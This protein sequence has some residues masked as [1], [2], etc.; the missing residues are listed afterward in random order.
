MKKNNYIFVKASIGVFSSLA[1]VLC[2]LSFTG[3]KKGELVS[4]AYDSDSLLPTTIDLNDTKEADIRGYYSS[5]NSLSDNERQG[6]NL[7]KNL[8]EILKNG[9]KYYSYDY[10]YGTGIKG[11][12]I[13]QMYE[14]VDRDWVKS[15]ASSTFYGT[16]DSINN[17]LV[18]YQYGTSNNDSKNNPYLHTLY[19]NRDVEN[20]TRAWGDHTQVGWGINREHIWAKSHG[21]GATASEDD[22]TSSGA[23]G[24]PMHLWSGNGYINGSDFHYHSNNFFG[25]V[26]LNQEYRDTLNDGSGYTYLSGNYEGYSLNK[27]SYYKVFEPQDSDKGDI[28]RAIF[29]MAARYNYFSGYDADGINENNPNLIITDNTYDTYRTGS[30]NCSESVAGQMGI[31]RD[32]LAWNRLD[33][34]DEWEIH[35]NNLLYNN[36]TNNRN[37]FIDYPEWAEYIWGK[38]TL[39]ND[40]RTI[41]SFNNSPTGVATPSSDNIS[42]FAAAIHP[43]DITFTSKPAE[44]TVGDNF[45]LECEITPSNATDKRVYY[46]ASDYNVVTISDTGYLKAVGPGEVT[47]TVATFDGDITD[48]FSIEV[49]APSHD[50]DYYLSNSSP[51]INGVPYK[52]YFH[53]TLGSAEKDYYFTGAMNGYYGASS[54]DISNAC[55]VYFEE[56]GD[57]QNMYFMSGGGTKNYLY[58]TVNGT[59]YNFTYGE[60]VPSDIWHY[61]LTY[62]CMILNTNNKLCTFGTYNQYTSFAVPFVT[63]STKNVIEFVTSDDNDDTLASATGLVTIFMNYINCDATGNLAPSYKANASWSVFETLYFKY[64]DAAKDLLADTISSVSGTDLEK[65]LARYDYIIAKYNTS[66]TTPFNDFLGRIDSMNITLGAFINGGVDIGTLSGNEL[67]I[68]IIVISSSLA[69]MATLLLT[70]KK[71]KSR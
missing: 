32:L 61:S 40:N 23:R 8:K 9:Q 27:G 39:A 60:G 48:S 5:L 69:A 18:N 2:A 11:I 35:R 26:D 22:P 70:I 4:E 62:G 54:D 10:N 21:M 45:Q 42:S 44:L 57:G 3:V 15:P 33:P 12:L 6:T 55:N 47:V 63:S 16:Y 52:M 53:H 56:N 67:T 50:T 37:P 19:V 34:P 28:A 59:H 25:F 41:T 68:I 17:R 43:T 30:Y 36:Y 13:W 49:S 14:I 38:P 51:Y 46:Y 1:L 31:L 20:Q 7:L 29:Y 71:R 64:S 66:S 65:G 58:I 24:D